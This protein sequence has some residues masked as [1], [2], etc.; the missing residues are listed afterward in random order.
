MV[1]VSLSPPRFDSLVWPPTI[2]ASSAGEPNEAQ[3][4]PRGAN[5]PVFLTYS[6]TVLVGLFLCVLP[7]SYINFRNSSIVAC[8]FM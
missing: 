3:I 8:A 6:L 2:A 4:Q 1:T 7:D 5:L